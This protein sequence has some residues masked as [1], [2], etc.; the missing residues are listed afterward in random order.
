MGWC[1]PCETEA[2]QE[3]Y[4][5]DERYRLLHPIDSSGPRKVPPP[6]LL[7]PLPGCHCV[8][9]GSSRPPLLIGMM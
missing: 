1:A 3:R 6:L 8:S 7:V 5:R 4:R 2:S 9:L